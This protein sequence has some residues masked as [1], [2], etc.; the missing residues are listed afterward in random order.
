MGDHEKRAF[1]RTYG[2][3]NA[4]K[5]TLQKPSAFGVYSFYKL[6][7]VA[8]KIYSRILDYVRSEGGSRNLGKL[9]ELL[10]EGVENYGDSQNETEYPIEKASDKAAEDEPKKISEE[11]C[12]EVGIN[13]LAHGPHIEFCYLKALLAKGNTNNSYAPNNSRKEPKSCA[14]ASKREEPQNVSYK[15]HLRRLHSIIL[16]IFYTR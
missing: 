2:S 7:V 9:L 16:V 4:K 12:S 14:D 1:S 10:A 15:F 3:L 11:A 6:T 13:S 5:N 8:F